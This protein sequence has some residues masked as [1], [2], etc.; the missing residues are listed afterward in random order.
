M[1]GAGKKRL[2]FAEM[3]GIEAKQARED[4]IRNEIEALKNLRASSA[5]LNRRVDS[6]SS[7]QPACCILLDQF[8]NTV[9]NN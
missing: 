1:S 4:G 5:M 7:G 6:T 9:F 3:R 2:F 8:C